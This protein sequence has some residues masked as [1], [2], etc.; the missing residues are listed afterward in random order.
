MQ[1]HR[2]VLHYIRVYTNNLHLNAGDRLTLLSS[3]SFDASVMDMYGALLN[4]ARQTPAYEFETALLL[5][6]CARWKRA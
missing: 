2:N 1:N 3:Y 5:R 4:G 6:A